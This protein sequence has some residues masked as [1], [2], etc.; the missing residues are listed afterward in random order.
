MKKVMS[1]LAKFQDETFPQNRDLFERLVSGQSPETLFITCSDSR[2]DPCMLTQ[3]KPGDLFICRN[4]GNI[5]PA[6]G[7]VIGGVAEF[8][9]PSSMPCWY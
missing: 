4:A 2:I 3:T 9:P 7:E 5:V 8:P 1:G 6:Y